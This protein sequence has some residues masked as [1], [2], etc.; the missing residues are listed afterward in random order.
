MAKL[1]EV[2][3]VQLRAS[4]SGQPMR[5]IGRAV[6]Y[7]SLSKVMP[8]QSGFAFRERVLPGAF[9]RSLASGSDVVSTFNHNE[10]DIPLGRTSSGTLKLSDGPQGL[11]FAVLLDPN[12]SAHKNL[13]SACQR[14]DVNQCSFGFSTDD[15]YFDDDPA[16]KDDD[17]NRCAR[18]TIKNATLYSVDVVVH[19]AYNETTV[20]ARGLGSKILNTLFPKKKSLEQTFVDANGFDPWLAQARKI[21]QDSEIRAGAERLVRAQ[22]NVAVDGVGTRDFQPG[23]QCVDPTQSLRCPADSTSSTKEEHERAVQFHRNIADHSRLREDYEFQTG[24]ADAHQSVVDWDYDDEDDYQDRVNR[25]VAGCRGPYNVQ[26]GM[27]AATA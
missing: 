1:V 13:Y 15:D 25:C 18:R 21:R 19:P 9:S 5:L 12:N 11:D 2:R 10:S 3:H 6:T 14:Q 23:G 16:C 27:S 24:L 7:N 17:G 4:D 20:A 8:S 22:R 26:H